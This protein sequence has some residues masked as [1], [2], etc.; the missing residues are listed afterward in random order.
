MAAF[1]MLH[2]GSMAPAPSTCGGAGSKSSWTNL[3]SIA[4]VN[5]AEEIQIII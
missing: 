2:E 3:I 1:C 5:T 4:L